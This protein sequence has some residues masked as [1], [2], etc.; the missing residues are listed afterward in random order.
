MQDDK[1]LYT[2]LVFR[3]Q[4]IQITNTLPCKETK[5]STRQM[6]ELNTDS[7]WRKGLPPQSKDLCGIWNSTTS[8]LKMPKEPIDP[9]PLGIQAQLKLACVAT[10]P[11]WQ[12][13]IWFQLAESITEHQSR[14]IQEGTYWTHGLFCTVKEVKVLEKYTCQKFLKYINYMLNHLHLISTF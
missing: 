12:Y 5:R 14:L 1:S 11:I 9:Y 6:S 3:H 2:S 10:N 4:P 13:Q 7:I 8:L